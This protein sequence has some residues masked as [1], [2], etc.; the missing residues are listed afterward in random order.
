MADT[1]TIDHGEI[2]PD[3]DPVLRVNRD[4]A[5]NFGWWRA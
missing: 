4:T 2:T 3:Q 1:L 5:N